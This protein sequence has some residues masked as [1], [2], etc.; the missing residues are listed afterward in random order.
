MAFENPE[1]DP[2]MAKYAYD[3]LAVHSH[4]TIHAGLE[5][6]K[7]QDSGGSLLVMSF[8]NTDRLL[9]LALTALMNGIRRWD[10]YFREN[11]ADRIAAREELFGRFEKLSASVESVN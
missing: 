10:G 4:P 1:V 6:V 7:P 3:Y 8:R 9:R 2:G 5:K 11:P